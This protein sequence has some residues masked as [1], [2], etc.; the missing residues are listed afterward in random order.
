[1]HTSPPRRSTRPRRPPS[2]TGRTLGA[3][4]LTGDEARSLEPALTARVRAAVLFPGEARCDPVRLAAAVGAAAV[5]RGVRLRTG[6]EV[7]AVGR[8][9][10]VETTHGPLRAGA[11]VVAAGAWSGR[12][13][14][15]R[16]RAPAAAGRQGLRGGVGPGGRARCGCRSTCTTSAWSPTRWP[17]GPG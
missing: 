10:G 14:R 6:T 15:E 13:A 4:V 8:D 2:E 9:G 17:T 16:R 7:Y 12:L 3:R 11:V 1:M 5:G